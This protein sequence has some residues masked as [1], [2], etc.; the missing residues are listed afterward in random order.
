L[1]LLPF[2]AALGENGD[3]EKVPAMMLE[4]DPVDALT[5]D[6]VHLSELASIVRGSL[7]TMESHGDSAAASDAKHDLVDAVESLRDE[8]LTHFALEE[9]GLFPFVEVK[10]PELQ[11]RA[12]SLAAAHDTVCGAVSRLLYL[13]HRPREDS[14]SCRA[15]FERFEQA[16][17]AHAEEEVRFLR[18]LGGRLAEPE[19]SELRRLILGL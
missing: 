5:H 15:A 3:G 11:E 19:R 17:A 10:A 18:D 6:H 16:Y 1:A 8:L 4:S 2:A 14:A 13:V 12:R 9:E 7:S